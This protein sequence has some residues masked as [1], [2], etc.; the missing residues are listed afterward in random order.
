MIFND[1]DHHL[2]INLIQV[3]IN[4]IQVI[5]NIRILHTKSVAHCPLGSSFLDSTISIKLK[6]VALVIIIIIVF[7]LIW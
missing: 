4:V 6:H 2:I 7:M 1:R 5:I 3:I